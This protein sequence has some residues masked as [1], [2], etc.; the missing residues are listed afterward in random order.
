LR[1][2]DIVHFQDAMASAAGGKTQQN[3]SC[4]G[5]GESAPIK[6]PW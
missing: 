3:G 6:L 2:R 4:Q 1:R 5:Q